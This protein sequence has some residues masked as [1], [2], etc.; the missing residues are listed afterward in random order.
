MS[1]ESNAV[2]EAGVVVGHE[3][4]RIADALEA[5]S[6]AL[7]G[8]IVSESVSV[9]Q[10]REAFPQLSIASAISSLVRIIGNR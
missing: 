1:D 2:N 9:G 4:A 5:I 7:S 6:M 10:N 3:L 8:H